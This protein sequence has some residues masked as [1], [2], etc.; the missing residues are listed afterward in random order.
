MMLRVFRG[1]RN[2]R[3][4]SPQ[5]LCA[6]LFSEILNSL[7]KQVSIGALEGVYKGKNTR[8]WVSFAFVG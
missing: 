6:D 5:I 7:V 1:I 2:I 8:R 3:N 4:G